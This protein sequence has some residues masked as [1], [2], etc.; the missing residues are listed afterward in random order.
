MA[1]WQNAPSATW[2]GPSGSASASIDIADVWPPGIS[3]KG[4][5]AFPPELHLSRLGPPTASEEDVL[6]DAVARSIGKPVDARISFVSPSSSLQP[7]SARSFNGLAERV[8]AKFSAGFSLDEEERE[9]FSQTLGHPDKLG[10]FTAF[11]SCMDEQ[12]FRE[13]KMSVLAAADSH[14]GDG[15]ATDFSREQAESW[16]FG[17]HSTSPV[18][19][20]AMVSCN[21]GFP[22]QVLVSATHDVIHTKRG[23]RASSLVAFDQAAARLMLLHL[24]VESAWKAWRA[25]ALGLLET[26]AFVLRTPSVPAHGGSE[27]A[28]ADQHSGDD[29]DAE[30]NVRSVDVA[31]HLA[32]TAH[33]LAGDGA[34]DVLAAGSSS[35][36]AE[37]SGGTAGAAHGKAGSAVADTDEFGAMRQRL[38]SWHLRHVRHRVLN[39]GEV[40]LGSESAGRL[41]QLTGQAALRHV[42]HELKARGFQDAAA[43]YALCDRNI[44]QRVSE[45]EL[46]RAL[47]ALGI[48]RVDARSILRLSSKCGSRN[49]IEAE[50]EV[51]DIDFCRLFSWDR[52]YHTDASGVFLGQEAAYVTLT[53]ARQNRRAIAAR[54]FENMA[55]MDAG[56]RPCEGGGGG[57]EGSRVRA[58]PRRASLPVRGR[59]VQEAVAGWQEDAGGGLRVFSPLGQDSML[60]GGEAAERQLAKGLESMHVAGRGATV[61]SRMSHGSVPTGAL[62]AGRDSTRRDWGASSA[63]LHAERA[64]KYT[65]TT[66]PT[67]TLALSLNLS[68]GRGS[69]ESISPSRSTPRRPPSRAAKHGSPGAG[70]SKGCTGGHGVNQDINKATF[71][72]PTSPQ[73]VARTHT[74]HPAATPN[75]S[76]RSREASPPG[77]RKGSPRAVEA[78]RSPHHTP[79]RL[80]PSLAGRRRSSSPRRRPPS[81]SPTR[82]SPM[83]LPLAAAPSASRAGRGLRAQGSPQGPGCRFCGQVH[84]RGPLAPLSL[85]W[86]APRH[87]CPVTLHTC[88][89]PLLCRP[90]SSPAQSLQSSTAWVWVC[91]ASC[92]RAWTHTRGD[93]ADEHARNR[94]TGARA[95]R[96]RPRHDR[97][98]AIGRVAAR[99]V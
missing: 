23:G 82:M 6:A 30:A 97:H 20:A 52:F 34:G 9:L 57:G 72:R 5:G 17:T 11:L 63:G 2:V 55:V 43:F 59:R 88:H 86:H 19:A 14:L 3:I 58:S 56:A 16:L 26:D 42:I 29:D 51:E 87:A 65:R 39:G 7:D 40:S 46:A 41:P 10:C 67:S 81:T 60:V 70:P 4:G 45:R 76:A 95:A 75:L 98:A 48:A 15:I 1:S 37:G 36:P 53:R 96:G 47:K 54:I 49:G 38:H 66:S 12:Q 68:G 83:L 93:A 62:T 84:L 35:R 73:H 79:T 85:C 44:R 21:Y 64:N 91:G 28:D 13:L 71:L 80:S 69:R 22:F 33:S 50:S 27:A 8:M 25:W 89:M 18:G 77:S 31:V 61:P 99:A 24:F 90:T 74:Y 92:L 78:L 94:A 32:G